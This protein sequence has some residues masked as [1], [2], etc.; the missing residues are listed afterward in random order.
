M[1]L[2]R[3]K[4]S[5]KGFDAL[6]V[7]IIT[8]WLELKNRQNSYLFCIPGA[9]SAGGSFLYAFEKNSYRKNVKP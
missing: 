4:Q 7:D 5:V 1:F 6:T 3:R 2:L 9:V 8:D